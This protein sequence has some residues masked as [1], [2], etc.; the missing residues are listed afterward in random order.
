[1]RKMV[2][3]MDILNVL[4]I[5]APSNDQ[6]AN[7]LRQQPDT[8]NTTL[9]SMQK[10]VN[11]LTGGSTIPAFYK[12]T[13]DTIINRTMQLGLGDSALKNSLKTN[14][15]NIYVAF[16]HPND[17]QKKDP[18][19]QKATSVIHPDVNL[20]IL[21][22]SIQIMPLR[23]YLGDDSDSNLKKYNNIFET[24]GYPFAPMSHVYALLRSDNPET[25]TSPP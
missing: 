25:T 3:S 23:V 6:T 17:V 10:F 7:A 24:V 4:E 14:V 15:K 1:M 5:Y 16:P 8:Y 13:D 9:P 21:N 18:A 11:V 19:D 2:F 22:R 12:Y 20:F